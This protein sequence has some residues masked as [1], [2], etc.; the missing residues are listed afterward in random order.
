MSVRNPATNLDA[1]WRVHMIVVPAKLGCSRGI[2]YDQIGLPRE[3]CASFSDDG[4]PATDSTNFGL[5]GNRK[6]RDIPRAFLRTATQEWT[7]T[8]NP[9]HQEQETSAD[10]SI[11][12]TTPSVADVFVDYPTSP[13]D[14]HA[15][16]LVLHPAVGKW[17][18]LGGGAYHL[19]EAYRRLQTL[20]HSV[21][22][23]RMRAKS[24]A[25]EA[26]R[27]GPSVYDG[28]ADLMP[29]LRKPMLHTSGQ[30]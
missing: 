12:T 21:S 7:H 6:Q 2:M 10:N 14:N 16:G 18:A 8:L 30:V 11:M 5:A 4:Y 25:M 27:S 20:G 26:A 9:I 23:R 15:A 22:A 29:D 19:N 28:F 17:V 3:G 24:D 1:E 13:E